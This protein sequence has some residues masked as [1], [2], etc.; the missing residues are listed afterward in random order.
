MVGGW[1]VLSLVWVVFEV[2]A[3]YSAAIR[4]REWPQL[5]AFCNF[6]GEGRLRY[7]GSSVTER[8]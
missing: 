6:H 8:M 1:L 5:L 3:V 2:F 4:V 7:Y